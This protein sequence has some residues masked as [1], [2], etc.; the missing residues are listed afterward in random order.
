MISSTSASSS[1]PTWS[2]DTSAE[3]GGGG[4]GAD[5][6]LP[7]PLAVSHEEAMHSLNPLQYVPVVGMV[8]RAATG[9]TIPAPMRVAGAG[10]LGGPLGMLGAA[11]TA[12]LEELIRMG[13]DLSRPSA[14]AGMMATGAEQ[15]VQPV[16]PGTL[17]EGQYTTL[18]TTIPDFLQ[19]SQVGIASA[20][21]GAATSATAQAGQTG[22]AAY[23]QA[24]ME[25][26][27]SQAVEKGLG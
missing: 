7:A 15:G 23:A 25:W 9:E 19:S 17:T 8:Y 22:Q 20:S 16:T 1:A 13:P 6:S 27:R 12:L 24:S 2:F 14:P 26:R 10:L 4:V 18:A 11:F 21:D 5:N 3:A